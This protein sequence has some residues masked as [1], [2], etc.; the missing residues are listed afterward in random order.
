[1]EVHNESEI[2]KKYIFMKGESQNDIIST[3]IFSQRYSKM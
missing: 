1:M 2:H 3:C